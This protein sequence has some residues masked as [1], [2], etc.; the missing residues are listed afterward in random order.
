MTRASVRVIGFIIVLFSVIPIQA[1]EP[2]SGRWLL[3]SQEIG[4]QKKPAEELMLRIN[5]AGKAFEFAYS[6]PVNDIQ[7]VSLKFSARLDGS[8]AD[9]MNAN[10]Q[11][12]G[13]VKVTKS[14]ALQYK[15]ILQG[16]N[17]PTASGTMTISADGKTLRSESDS[18]GRGQA[19]LIHTVQIFARQ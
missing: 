1:A 2:L 6:V 3:V 5:P 7:F 11:K 13:T 14:G 4:G 17:R 18:S 16:Q 15:I 8:E 10:G 19:G 12:I 9:V